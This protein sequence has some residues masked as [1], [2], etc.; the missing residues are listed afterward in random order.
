MFQ[1][2]CSVWDATRP[3]AR[4]RWAWAGFNPRAPYGAR[5]PSTVS[6]R[7]P[8]VF[9]STRPVRGRDLSARPVPVRHVVSI[10]APRAGRDF[11]GW[12]WLMG[13][14][15]F[16]STR[17][18]RGATFN[19]RAPCG[20]RRPYES[21]AVI[22][23]SF[24]STR[25]VRGAT[26][27]RPTSHGAYRFQ[28]TRPVRGATRRTCI[29]GN[30]A[31]GFNPRAPCGARPIWV[32]VLLSCCVFQSTRPVRG[33]TFLAFSSRPICSRFQST[34]P[35]RGATVHLHRVRQLGQVSI[36]APR[37]G[38]DVGEAQRLCG[39]PV[40]IHAPRAGRDARG[41]GHE[42]RRHPVSIH[43]PRAGRDLRGAQGRQGQHVS[44]HAPRA[45]RDR[46]VRAKRRAGTKFQ[47]TRPVR[48]ATG[49]V[50]GFFAGLWFQS[51]RPV[52][53]ATRRPRWR[54]WQPTSFNPR[55]P[56]GARLGI[57]TVAKVDG[58][59]QSTRPVRGATWTGYIGE[60]GR[61]FQSTRPVRGATTDMDYDDGRTVFQSTR[62]VRGATA[63]PGPTPPT[64]RSF[65]P[66][67]PCGARR[68]SPRCRARGCR[69]NPR[70]PCG[71]RRARFPRA[72]SGSSF[73]PRA[74]CGARP[75]REGPGGRA[76]AVSIHAPRAGRD[77]VGA[78]GRPRHRVSIHA[79][80]A[81][82]DADHNG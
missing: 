16:Q 60:W 35:V 55:A 47:S 2:T 54:R 17:P 27:E 68:R 40:S 56:C 81:G 59:F 24:Q 70:A 44:I 52:R 32:Q 49:G 64:C 50:A 20:A 74:P 11:A 53:G 76:D 61:V 46:G 26:S 31:R 25:P 67:A 4:W 62:P 34:R 43:A 69:F 72:S 18:V 3:A 13:Y 42:A 58:P 22:V 12:F 45:G 57:V 29:V 6:F 41:R 14:H 33:A 5:L 21:A 71:A 30:S 10:H 19:P 37:A 65:N 15:A 51:T 78:L 36:H 28:S 73:N 79:P 1:S 48:G 8:P 63:A 23:S 9:Q 82:R 66:R 7:V 77:R 39:V 38:R 75:G 80:R